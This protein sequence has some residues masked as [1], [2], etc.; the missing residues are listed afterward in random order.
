MERVVRAALVVASALALAYG[1]RLLLAQEQ[2]KVVAA[3]TWLLAGVILHDGVLVPLVLGIAAVLTLLHVQLPRPIVVGLIV[4][5]SVT[6][7]VV[8]MLGRFGA[9]PDNATLLD[10][11]YLAGWVIFASVTLGLSALATLRQRDRT[12]EA[13]EQVGTGSG[14]R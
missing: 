10:R 6:L 7:A 13:G 1:V 8:P 12:A 3:G 14:R 11:N 2:D 9:R 4:I 5:G